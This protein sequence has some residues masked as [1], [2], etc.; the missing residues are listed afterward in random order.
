MAQELTCFVCGGKLVIRSK[1]G[2]VCSNCSMEYSLEALRES[3]NGG[4]GAPSAPVSVGG[5]KV[6]DMKY[7]A[8]SAYNNGEYDKAITLCD[9]ILMI[10]RKDPEVW[11]WKIAS[12]SKR[13]SAAGYFADA[14]K[15]IED[16]DKKA[17]FM[18]DVMALFNKEISFREETVK[19]AEKLYTIDHK[20][21]EDYLNDA[22]DHIY[23]PTEKSCATHLKDIKEYNEKGS[24]YASYYMLAGKDWNNCAAFM[25]IPHLKLLEMIV[26]GF[27]E[28]CAICV[29][30]KKLLDLLEKTSAEAEKY[31][32]GNSYFKDINPKI[33]SI[34]SYLNH[35]VELER[36]RVRLEET[37]KRAQ[38][39]K[40]QWDADPSLRE[41][42][43]NK[44]ADAKHAIEIAEKNKEEFETKRTA[45]CKELDGQITMWE[46]RLSKLPFYKFKDKKEIRE[47]LYQLWDQTRRTKDQYNA[48]I[49]KCEAEIEKEQN[50]IDSINEIFE[51]VEE[52][53][54]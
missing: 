30:A 52:Y 16:G 34:K 43:L 13:E 46:Y 25:M 21:A 26:K 10:D 27:G 32:G 37:K 42:E 47:K 15:Q 51:I 41:K 23:P 3:M 50:K 35:L 1:E 4:A 33:S 12:T 45:E 40:K 5:K 20:L 11:Y 38:S 14:C 29:K 2:A 28:K 49:K 22:F 17:K 19:I 36:E 7:M 8:G 39:I 54:E 24:S 6:D 18:K 9:E 53:G 44:L 31:V 48:K